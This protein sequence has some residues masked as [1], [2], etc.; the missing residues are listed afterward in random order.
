MTGTAKAVNS[1]Q[2][3]SVE[4]LY[5]IIM[6]EMFD[7]KSIKIKDAPTFYISAMWRSF[8][9][10]IDESMRVVKRDEIVWRLRR[11]FVTHMAKT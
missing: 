5:L 3:K 10:G 2:N 7:P 9:C 1:L 11:E 8:G 6:F 4:D